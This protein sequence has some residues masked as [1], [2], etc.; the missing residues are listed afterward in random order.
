MPLTPRTAYYSLT[1]IFND[2]F[3]EGTHSLNNGVTTS[4]ATTM[5]SVASSLTSV[6][7]LP[8]NATRKGAALYNESTA[9]LYI[10]FA[11]TASITAYT[12][13]VPANSSYQLPAPVYTGA[14]SGIWSAANGFARITE[15]T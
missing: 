14:I 1:E 8:A 11:A 9:I 2:L 6:A 10:A 3:N 15:L 12:V 13:Q 7:L 4:S 5:T